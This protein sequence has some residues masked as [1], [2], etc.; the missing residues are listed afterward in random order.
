MNLDLFRWGGRFTLAILCLGAAMMAVL[1]SASSQTERLY[2]QAQAERGKRLYAQ[3]CASCH[4]QSLEGTPSSPL[5]GER[6]M[7]KWNERALGELYNI[8]KME[9]PYGKPDS[10]TVEQY[11]DIVAFM[12]SSN[13]YAAGPREL[14]A[15]EAKLKQTRI[16]RQSGVPVAKTAAPEFFSSGAK[17]STAGPTQAELNAA[18]NNNTDW[19]HSNHDYGGQRFVDLK[20]INRSNAASLQPVAIYQ[21]ADANVFHNNPLVYQGVMYVSTSNATMALD[22]TTLKVKWRVDRKPKG[23]DGW[24][25]YRGVALKDGKVIRGTH[26]GYLVAYDAANGKLLWER[27]ILD[28]KKREAGFTMAPLLYEDLILIGP[29]G[30][31]SG[32]KGWV[33]AFRLEDGA[34]VWRFN[35]VPDEGEPGAETWKD[36]T[37]LTTGGGSIWAPL[38]LDPVKGVLYVPV[39]NPAPDFYTDSRLGNNLYTNSL[40][41][42]DARTGK[43]QWFYQAVPADFHD[44]DVTQVSP[45]FETRINGKMRK[46][47]T[48]TGKD[49]LLHVLDRETHEHLYAVPVTT[50]KNP[51]VPLNTTEGVY[52]CPGVLGGVQWNGPAYNPGLNMLFVNA[53]DWCSTF[54]KAKEFRAGVG[55]YMGGTSVRDPVEQSRGWLTAIDA[56]TGQVRWKY[57]SQRPMLA[58]VTTTSAELIFTGELTGDFLVL[59]AR[60]GKVLYRFNAGGPLNGGIISYAINGRQYIAVNSGNAT[61][62]WLAAKG[63]ATVLLFALPQNKP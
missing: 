51:D 46:L 11:L 54:K 23:P 16:A 31:E 49:G 40:L 60:D 38:S 50:R 41:A 34:P 17:A 35:T 8:T 62:F 29:A 10:L 20:Q 44:W 22:A 3:H 19:L 39:S 14:T 5:A 6:F 4:G 42:L 55:G 12:L 7:A 59:D 57:E 56:A 53:V 63:S 45:L 52:A 61:G 32:V 1:P 47:I 21:V 48:T 33:G 9:M 25:M 2:S 26:D 27:P 36:P 15:D 13:G 18:A 43:L 28:R 37:A 58:A 30:S 24:L